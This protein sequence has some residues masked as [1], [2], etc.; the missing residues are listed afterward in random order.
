MRLQNLRFCLRT[1]VRDWLPRVKDRK[2]KLPVLILIVRNPQLLRKLLPVI[3]EI[4][5][6]LGHVR[7]HL[8]P[9]LLCPF[10]GLA[11][12][13]RLRLRKL[14]ATQSYPGLTAVQTP[15]VPRVISIDMFPAARV[16]SGS[17]SFAAGRFIRTLFF[18]CLDRSDLGSLW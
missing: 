13:R 11:F 8:R 15:V 10:S 1:R 3:P 12:M 17:A 16:M 4:L 2:E 18:E 5:L 7:D 6:L 9:L 14:S